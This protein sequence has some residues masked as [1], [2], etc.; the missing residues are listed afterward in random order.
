MTKTAT[1]RPVTP[2]SILAARLGALVDDAHARGYDNPA[3]IESLVRACDIAASLDPYLAAHTSPPSPALAELAAATADEDWGTRFTQA[4][5]GLA[6]EQEMLSGHIEGQT[7]KMLVAATGARSVLEVGLFTGYSALA[8]AE[9]LPDDG[10]LV[11]CEIDDFAADFAARHF[12]AARHGHKITIRRGPAADSLAQ[13]A[14]EDARFDFVF[15]DAD[16]AGYIDY[17]HR[18]VDG[19]LAPNGL[20]CVDNTL[21]QGEPYLNSAPSANGQAIAAFNTAVMA[22]A[23]LETVQLPL[24]DGLTLIRRVDD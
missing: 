2:I 12:N 3:F 16:K 24:R 11:A 8:M 17:L 22:D 4:D 7:L 18:I 10:R 6:L 1:P 15:I 9:G 23:R 20:I 5:T 13:L 14:A 21:M 19:L